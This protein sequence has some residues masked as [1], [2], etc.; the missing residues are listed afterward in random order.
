MND[1]PEAGSDPQSMECS[2]V[3]DGDDYILNGT[4]CFITNGG[5]AEVYTIIA[6]TDKSKGT[7]GATAFIVEKDTP[8]FTF[9][10]KEKTSLKF[11][12]LKGR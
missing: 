12:T 6:M 11:M 9:G 10:K 4:K 8:G 1:V 5:D 3:K 2:A 7:R